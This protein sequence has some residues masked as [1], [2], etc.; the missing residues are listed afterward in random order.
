MW[1]FAFQKK[2][3]PPPPREEIL[4]KTKN[5][6]GILKTFFFMGQRILIKW[7][8]FCLKAFFLKMIG[9]KKRTK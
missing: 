3:P 1:K 2:F 4:E 8:F 9:L 6:S 5:P 7:E